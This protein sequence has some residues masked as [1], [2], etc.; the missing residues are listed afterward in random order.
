MCIESTTGIKLL[1]K[2]QTSCQYIVCKHTDSWDTKT[3]L[4]KMSG[5]FN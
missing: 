5:T 3:Y 4:D 2:K 1:K